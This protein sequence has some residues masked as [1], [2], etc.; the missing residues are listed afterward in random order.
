MTHG[1]TQCRHGQ[2][3]QPRDL[4]EAIYCC[5][6][7]SDIDI[8]TIAERLNVRVS[9]L[10]DATNPDR[11][12][13]QFQARLLIPLM[14]V[15]GNI[16]PLRFMA[17]SLDRALIDLP[18]VGGTLGDIRS[19]FMKAVRELGEDATTIEEVLADN[20]VS[21]DDVA[22][23]KVEL[24]DTIEVLLTVQKQFES[25]LITTEEAR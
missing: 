19:T 1:R 18:R 8:K 3:C 24:A 22:R 15:T 12:N 14:V 21:A 11:P 10:Y 16:A 13:A 9:Y 2:Q 17:M 6:H 5:A 25:R 20:H 23:V 4:A 7:H